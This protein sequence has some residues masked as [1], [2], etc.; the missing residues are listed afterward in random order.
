MIYASIPEEYLVLNENDPLYQVLW[1][2]YLRYTINYYLNWLSTEII[3][4]DTDETSLGMADTGLK[5]K[6]IFQVLEK[7]TDYWENVCE[8]IGRS[9][10]IAHL[11]KHPKVQK[12]CK[13]FSKEGVGDIILLNAILSHEYKTFELENQK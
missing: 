10:N 5:L 11:I 8:K 1:C 12:Y 6:E 13:I 3:E 4:A 9:I 7:E 2:Y